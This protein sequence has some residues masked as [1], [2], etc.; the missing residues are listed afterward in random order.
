VRVAK[1]VAPDQD[2]VTVMERGYGEYRR[3]YPALKSIASGEDE[4]LAVG[5]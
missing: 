1:T 4:W 3:I 5:R 2:A